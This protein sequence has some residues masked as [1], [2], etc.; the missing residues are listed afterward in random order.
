MHKIK[1]FLSQLPN[2]FR[3]MSMRADKTPLDTVAALSEFAR[4]RS[5]F[6]AQTALY[7][8]LKTRMG[9]QFPRYFE[10]D[11]FSEGIR[12]SAMKVFASCLADM[13]VFAVA[14]VAAGGRLDAD[15][16]ASLA[17]ACYREELTQGLGGEDNIGVAERAIPNFDKRL[18]ET[19]WSTAGEGENAFWGSA[20]DLVEFAPV[21]DQFKELDREIVMNS[22]RF[23]WRDVREQFRRRIDADGV[24]RDWLEKAAATAETG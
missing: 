8:Y 3:S 20:R 21:I 15:Q 19:D 4:T 7:G 14:N 9:T 16:A 6:I 5:S 12:Q 1:A 13:T 18:G 2:P 17:R 10:D 11:V 23:R 22:I 24:R